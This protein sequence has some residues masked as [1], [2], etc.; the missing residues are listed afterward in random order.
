M[1]GLHLQVTNQSPQIRKFCAVKETTNRIIIKKRQ[2]AEWGN[3]FADFP[4]KSVKVIIQ[5][6]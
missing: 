5:D 2:P 4:L 3:I 6:A 1:S